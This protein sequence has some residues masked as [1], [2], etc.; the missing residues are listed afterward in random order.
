MAI[1]GLQFLQ[2]TRPSYN[3]SKIQS[4]NR[5][6]NYQPASPVNSQVNTGYKPSIEDFEKAQQFIDGNYNANINQTS[7]L[8][9]TPETNKGAAFDGFSVPQN[10][11]TG[12]LIADVS[13]REDS[14]EGCNWQPYFA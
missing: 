2:A 3:A 5:Q 4:N 10:N 6:I 13:N 12:E 1:E 7:G 14:I 11:G 8:H 9:R